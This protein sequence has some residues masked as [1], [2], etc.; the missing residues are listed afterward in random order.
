M[1][2]VTE[3]TA[4]SELFVSLLRLIE[5]KRP[6][7]VQTHDYPDIDAVASAWALSELLERQGIHSVCVHRGEI[8]NRS[9]S[10]LVAELKIMIFS[11]PPTGER[12]HIIVV[13]GSPAN[14]NVEL[15]EGDLLGVID[16]HQMVAKPDAPFVDIRPE[17]AACATII[18]SYWSEM[19]LMPPRHTATAL[20]AGVQSDTDFLSSRA[21]HLDFD[22]YISLLQSGDWSMAS[23]IVKS[24]L[25]IEELDHIQR[26][27]RDA[28]VR[29]RLFYAI[30][31]GHC[32]QE[33]LAVLA[34]FTLRVEEIDI[35]VV[36]GTNDGGAHF[37]VRSKNPAVSA[38]ELV[39]K[40]LNGIGS[41][42]GH[43]H[44]AGGTVPL[45]SNPGSQ[46][47]K[48]RFFSVAAAAAQHSR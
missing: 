37:S 41:G 1:T 47:L 20:L 16:H 4:Q 33:V 24:V 3:A 45:S 36:V 25:S 18:R 12:A 44:S 48:E 8:R 10:R 38:F 32:A 7:L 19:H 35:V 23:R 26:A 15:F 31:P 22:A 21:S 42:G 13:D 34:D 28:E 29:N 39:R 2:D 40:A 27:I 11:A 14:G 9:L 46:A 5:P 17:V 30:V 43:P 6:L